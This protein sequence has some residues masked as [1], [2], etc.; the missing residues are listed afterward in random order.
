MGADNG[1]GID[2]GEHE[3][4]F[5][6]LVRSIAIAIALIAVVLILLALTQT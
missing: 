4:A 6:G 1:P 5:H 2:P 3:R